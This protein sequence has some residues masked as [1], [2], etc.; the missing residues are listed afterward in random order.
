[1]PRTSIVIAVLFGVAIVAA[2]VLGT[3]IW[4]S[5]KTRRPVDEQRLHE[6]ERTWLGIVILVLL[7]L[8]LA[9]IWFA[10]YGDAGGKAAQHVRVTAQQF[11]WTLSPTQ[12]RAGQSVEFR[13]FSKDVNHGFGVYDSHHRLVFQIQVVPGKEQDVVH[14]FRSPGR[15]DVLCLE[16]CGVGHQ[17]M[18]SSFQVT[19]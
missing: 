17:L 5:T 9:T 16:F 19:R 12:I 18:A 6:H 11:A 4:W 2:V 14:T 13:L 8:L 7:T 1:M 15:Y 3:G 10:P